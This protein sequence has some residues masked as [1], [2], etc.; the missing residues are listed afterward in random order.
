MKMRLFLFEGILWGLG[1]VNYR[2]PLHNALLYN[3]LQPNNLLLAVMR[4]AN[5]IPV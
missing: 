4:H 1:F 2:L 3:H 5:N